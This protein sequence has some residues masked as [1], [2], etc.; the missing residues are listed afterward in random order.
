MTRPAPTNIRSLDARIRN[1]VQRHGVAEGRIRRLVGIVVIGQLLEKAE[2]AVVKGASNIEVRVGTKGSRVSSDVD[3]TRR[4]TLAELRERLA[5]ELRTGWE[6]FTG[7]LVDEGEIE[8]PA[9]DGYRPHR[10]QVKLRYRG[11][12]FGTTTLEVS[13]EEVDGLQSAEAV[14]VVDA[15]AWFAE[16]GL[17]APGPVPTLPL[18]HQI[19]QKLHA[20]TAPD[21]E[22]WVNNRSHDL[23]DLQLAMRAY[24]G[25]V[26]EIRETAVRLFA[27]RRGHPWPPNVTVRP[28]WEARY[29]TQADGLDVL[30]DVDHAVAWANQ[31]VADIEARADT[32]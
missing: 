10:F 22:G 7:T 2:V 29:R 6:G 5:N 18:Q 8:T 11:G 1:L 26:A 28:G 12:S 19:A 31:L 30:E 17:P 21:V 25:T 32:R 16:L 13:P 27:S 9:P 14:A 23:I 24:R 4:L 20:C 15:E 3:A